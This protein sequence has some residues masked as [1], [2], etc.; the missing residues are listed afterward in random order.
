MCSGN[1]RCNCPPW[2]TD[3]HCRCR[4]SCAGGRRGLAVERYGF[5]GCIGTAAGV[6]NFCG[7]QCA[8]FEDTIGVNGWPVEADVA[9]DV[10]FKWSNEH[11]RGCN[12]LT[13]RMLLPLRIDS[14]LVA[15]RC[16]AGPHA[17][18]NSYR[19]WR[20]NRA[21]GSEPIAPPD[22]ELWGVPGGCTESAMRAIQPYQSGRFAPTPGRAKRLLSD[23]RGLSRC[24]RGVLSRYQRPL[25]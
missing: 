3:R 19:S 1:I 6:T 11:T 10:I 24:C 20:R 13:C 12:H 22:Q 9:G 17:T 8:R 5:L 21:T 25:L 23:R 2:R 18:S 16:A 15:G 7:L 4:I 14:L